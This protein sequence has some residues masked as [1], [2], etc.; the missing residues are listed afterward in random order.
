MGLVSGETATLT[1]TDSQT[2]VGYLNRIRHRGVA[3]LLVRVLR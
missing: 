1:T 2:E 3:S